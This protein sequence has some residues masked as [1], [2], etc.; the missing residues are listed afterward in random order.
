MQQDNRRCDPWGRAEHSAFKRGTIYS[1]VRCA[2]ITPV[3]LQHDQCARN[4]N[5]WIFPV[6][7][8]G[9]SS[10]IS[11]HRGYFHIPTLALT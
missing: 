4:L 9:S 2:A 5:R 1:D 8:F 11:I 3:N 6:A 7:V 10:T